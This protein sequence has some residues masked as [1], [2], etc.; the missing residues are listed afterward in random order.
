M[1]EYTPPK[2]AFLGIC[3]KSGTIMPIE[4]NAVMA[5]VTD[6]T[7]P[8]AIYPMALT[9]V[10]LK[11]LTFVCACGDP[12]CSAVYTYTASRQGRHPRRSR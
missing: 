10:T 12:E 8:Q 3:T 2:K 5:I 11:A 4:P 6:A 7:D 9:K 1:S